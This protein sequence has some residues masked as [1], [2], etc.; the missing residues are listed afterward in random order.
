MAEFQGRV[1]DPCVS[2]SFEKFRGMDELD[3][4]CHP[5][6]FLLIHFFNGLIR[7]KSQC[8]CGL[9]PMSFDELTLEAPKTIQV[10]A[11]VAVFLT[12]HYM[13]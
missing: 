9:L 1:F 7:C 8:H 6:F 11:T 5:G 10:I 4:G 13:L 2:W 3:L 12:E